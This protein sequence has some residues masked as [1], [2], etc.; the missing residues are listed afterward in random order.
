MSNPRYLEVDSTYRNRNEYP[1]AGR[2]V[3]P[4]SQTGRKGPIDAVDPVSEA[5][6][7]NVWVANAFDVV[8]PGIGLL[9]AAPAN[10]I[11]STVFPPP[12]GAASGN[13]LLAIMLTCTAGH[14]QIANGYY[15][16]A[17][18]RTNNDTL[19]SRIADYQY[20]GTTLDTN[21]NVVDRLQIRLFSPIAIA[22]G[23]AVNIEDPTDITGNPVSPQ[24][25][26][27]SG[28]NAPNAYPGTQIHNI[29]IN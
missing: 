27:P 19:R 25:F 18:L 20:K 21:N 7:E 2:F 23:D 5:G 22:P 14:A 28:K 13:G 24:I 12:T 1:Q 17:V 11:V 4:I 8:V 9:S 3:V 6:A 10:L 16:N 26:V 29:S 15:N